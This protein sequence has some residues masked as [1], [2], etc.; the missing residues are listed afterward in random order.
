M[1]TRKYL[2]LTWIGIAA[3][4]AAGNASGQ[5]QCNLTDSIETCW[6]KY[7]P[8]PNAQ[9]N[10]ARAERQATAERDTVNDVLELVTGSGLLGG[11]TAS[12]VTNF[13]PLMMFTGFGGNVGGDNSTSSSSDQD[14][15]FDLNLPFFGSDGENAIKLQAIFARKRDLFEPL[16]NATPEANRDA[17][18]TAFNNQSDLGDDLRISVSYNLTNKVFGRTFRQ[19]RDR[20]DAL[21]TAA[22]SGVSPGDLG[23][24]I[25]D[26]QRS[27]REELGRN[28]GMPGTRA[29]VG[30]WLDGSSLTAEEIAQARLTLI[31]KTEEAARATANYDAALNASLASYR[32]LDFRQLVDNQPQLT[33]SYT[34]RERDDLIG[35]DEQ[36]ATVTFEF[37]LGAN[38]WSFSRKYASECGA[39]WNNT[40]CLERFR[41]Y[42]GKQSEIS[43]LAPRLSLSVDWGKI[44]DYNVTIPDPMVS[45]SQAGS[46]K[47]VV[48][49]AF[50]L[51]FNGDGAMRDTRFDLAYK[52]EDLSDDPMRNSRSVASATWTK[53]FRGL[54]VPIT[55][56][57]SNKPEFLDQQALGERLSANIGIKYEFRQ[58]KQ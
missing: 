1:L 17:L 28:P 53:Q 16:L 48:A 37:P 13:L 9:L 51:R 4:S 22:T 45:Y 47:I 49:L 18:R 58:Y 24:K 20:F 35:P 33:F 57:Y 54:S 21:F 56:I 8:D 55:L 27:V 30:D 14:L 6:Q 10:A 23:T 2:A 50:G 5:N 39:N 42:V 36:M 41:D 52:Y 32:V 11:D 12:S 44:D 25:P 31:A 7:L 46:D 15:A 29:I 19:H 26:I 38:L 40:Q 3:L 34:A 43:K